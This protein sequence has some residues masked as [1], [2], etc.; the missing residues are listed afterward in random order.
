MVMTAIHSTRLWITLIVLLMINVSCVLAA[1]ETTPVARLEE[2]HTSMLASSEALPAIITPISRPTNTPDTLKSTLP[3]PSITPNIMRPLVTSTI[4]LTPTPD[5]T[6]TPLNPNNIAAFIRNQLEDPNCKLPCFMGFY[7]S[8]TSKQE[9]EQLLSSKASLVKRSDRS[10]YSTL[11]FEF[12]DSP[13]VSHSH[14]YF[15]QY[16]IRQ[17]KFSEVDAE[18]PLGDLFKIKTI[19]ETYGQATDIWLEAQNMGGSP[20][21]TT[22]ILKIFLYYPHNGFFLAHFLQA[23]TTETN[24]RACIDDVSRSQIVIWDPAIWDPDDEKTIEERARA[25]DRAAMSFY[26]VD[27]DG[28]SR[29]QPLVDVTRYTLESFHD[30]VINAESPIC[31]ETLFEHW[32][33]SG[34]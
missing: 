10:T 28:K 29:E 23:E 24:V 13:L 21:G 12:F 34:E 5:P 27:W 18:L 9:I 14:S 20:E 1:V 32:P 25:N 6:N 4:V 26:G 8:E 22:A 11:I 30:A 7:P 17:G 31:I 16:K 19:F 33:K 3:L 2:M 15:Q